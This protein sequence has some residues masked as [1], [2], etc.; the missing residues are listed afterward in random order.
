MGRT[1]RKIGRWW[2]AEERAGQGWLLVR[3]GD[4]VAL[5]PSDKYYDEDSD[6]PY[7]AVFLDKSAV[8]QLIADLTTIAG[9]EP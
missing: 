2:E 5:Y 8:A 7:I 9:E 4:E 1:V 3:E 6:D